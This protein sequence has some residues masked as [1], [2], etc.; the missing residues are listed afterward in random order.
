MTDIWCIFHLWE[1]NQVVRQQGDLTFV[2]MLNSFHVHQKSQALEVSDVNLLKTRL[3]Y[4]VDPEFPKSS[5]HVYST[6]AQ[7]IKHNDMMFQELSKNHELIT[8]MAADISLHRKTQQSFK[9]KEPLIVDSCL[10][11]ELI[12]CREARVMLTNILDV[13][14]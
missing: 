3:I 13:K 14:D 10:P 1:L 5:L 12:L 9:F 8:V 7:I 4:S 6:R 2:N 11:E